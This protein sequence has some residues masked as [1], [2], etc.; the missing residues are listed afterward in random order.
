MLEIIILWI[1][2]WTYIE[3]L[4][5]TE[6]GKFTFV[7]IISLSIDDTL[8]DWLKMIFTVIV[9][10]LTLPLWVMFFTIRWIK[11]DFKATS[12]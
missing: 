9:V 12:D 7:Y 4:S 3:I 11:L 5:F 10:L 2:M 1:G 6:E 8:R